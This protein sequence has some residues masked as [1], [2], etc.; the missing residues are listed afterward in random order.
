MS[1]L[2]TKIIAREIPASIIYEDENH[3]AFLDINPM[4]K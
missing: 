2:F 4:E 3:L 1:S